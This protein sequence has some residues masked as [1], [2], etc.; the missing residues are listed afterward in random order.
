M[1]ATDIQ[2]ATSETADEVI[3]SYEEASKAVIQVQDE[4]VNLW[5]DLLPKLGSPQEFRAKLQ[6]MTADAFRKARSRIEEFAETFNRTS[7]QTIDLC[8]KTLSVYQATSIPDAQRRVEDLIKASLTALR[9]NVDSALNTNAK[10]I[11]DWKELV[12]PFSPAIIFAT[13]NSIA[14]DIK[15]PGDTPKKQLPPPEEKGEQ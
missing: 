4:S 3:Q 5:R 2:K 12:Y 1:S 9:V 6:S 11:A 13:P 15:Q 7:N 8:Q 14:A 10:I